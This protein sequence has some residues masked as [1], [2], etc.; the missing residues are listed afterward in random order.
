VP[1]LNVSIALSILFLGPEIMRAWRGGTSLTIRQP[2]IVALA[3]GLLHG[4][5]FCSAG[6]CDS[7]GAREEANLQRSTMA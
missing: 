6:R 7:G 4:F 2:W 1:P 3:F 5:G